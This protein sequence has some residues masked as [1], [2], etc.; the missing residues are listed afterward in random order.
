MVRAAWPE[1]SSRGE[2]EISIW[3]FAMSE[4]EP[5]WYPNPDGSDDERYWDGL[6]WTAQRRVRDASIR[7]AA[8]GH[9]S[10]QPVNHTT[11]HEPPDWYPDPDGSGGERYWDGERWTSRGR[12]RAEPTPRAFGSHTMSTPTGAVI[13]RNVCLALGGIAF[14]VW[15]CERF[16]MTVTTV[17]GINCQSQFGVPRAELDAC[18]VALDNYHHE[19]GLI[20][21]LAA[22]F[23]IVALVIHLTVKRT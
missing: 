10:P 19:L 18:T 21:G 3:G 14:I 4:A 12:P 8:T 2:S 15:F 16:F 23:F 13:A 20:I 17:D 7:R 22:V 5:G 6:R 9:S 1:L 11:T